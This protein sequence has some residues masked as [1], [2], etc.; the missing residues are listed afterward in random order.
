LFCEKEGFGPLFKAVN[1]ANRYDLMIVST[2]GVSVTAAR[3]LIDNVCGD[4]G[5]PLFTLHD[6]DVAG[7]LILGTLQRDTRRYQFSND[8]EVIDLGLRLADITGLEREPAAATRTS[9]DILRGQLAE[10]GADDEEIA[11]LLDERVELNA[12]ASDALIAMIETK[13]KA[14]GL[15]KVI[16]DDDLLAET[17]CAFHRSQQLREKFAEMEEQFDE[18]AAIKIPRGLKKR[19]RAI[20][21]EHDDL[22]WDDAIRIALDETTLDRV[23]EEKQKARKKSGDFAG[24]GEDDD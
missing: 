20:L 5:L 7:F 4:S 17:Y 24:A 10:N 22:R 11:I 8:L 14:Y 15:K 18:E 3:R 6:F 2:K 12:M 23:R 13:L 16:P 19:V 9:A 1:L 21:S